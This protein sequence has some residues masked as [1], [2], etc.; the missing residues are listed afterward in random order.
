LDDFQLSGGCDR[1]SGSLSERIAGPSSERTAGAMIDSRFF[2]IAMW[3]FR[4][5]R[6]PKNWNGM[7]ASMTLSALWIII[8]ALELSDA[9]AQFFC[10]SPIPTSGRRQDVSP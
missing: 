8:F 6:A 1:I 2:T 3:S 10:I 9:A 5:A 7:T 4:F